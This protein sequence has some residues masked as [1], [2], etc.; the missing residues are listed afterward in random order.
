[1]LISVSLIGPEELRSVV[2]I[3]EDA[4]VR[5]VATSEYHLF[6]RTLKR[7]GIPVPFTA[8]VKD[9]DTVTV[10]TEIVDE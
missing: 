1:V 3:S 7:N 8:R 10:A 9:G 4:T 6:W 2:R 5:D